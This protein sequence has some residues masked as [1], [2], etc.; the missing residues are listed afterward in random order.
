MLDVYNQLSNSMRCKWKQWF[1]ISWDIDRNIL[2]IVMA[3]DTWST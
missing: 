1:N 2:N 3:W